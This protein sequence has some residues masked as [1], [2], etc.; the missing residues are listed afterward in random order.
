MTSISTKAANTH[1]DALQ[2]AGDEVFRARKPA[3]PKVV[4]LVHVHADH[5]NVLLRRARDTPEPVGT[6]SAEDHVCALTD[7]LPAA[8]APRSGVLKLSM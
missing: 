8:A 1:I 7:C 6:T 3:P 5:H 2:R 4:I